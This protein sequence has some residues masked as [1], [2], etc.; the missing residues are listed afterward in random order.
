M[1]QNRSLPDRRRPQCPPGA[2]SGPPAGRRGPSRGPSRGSLPSRPPGRPAGEQV[3]GGGLP[4]LGRPAGRGPSERPYP[5]MNSPPSTLITL[6]LIQ[7]ESVEAS[8]TSASAT[9]ATVVI[10]ACGLRARVS[11]TTR[12]APGI[13]RSAGVSVTPARIALTAASESIRANSIPSWRQW[14]SSAAFADETAPYDG[15]IRADPSEV[16]AKTLDPASRKPPRQR[17]SLIH[18]SEPTRLG[19]ISYAVFCLKKKKRTEQ[20]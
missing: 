19:M 1:T 6:P 12:A 4:R 8:V 11:S 10:R 17:L 9:S 16:I 2:H 7:S 15:I 20:E 13:L 18:I 3:R 5:V 14:D